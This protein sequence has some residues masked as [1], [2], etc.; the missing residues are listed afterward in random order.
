MSKIIEIH[1]HR[2]RALC[3]LRITML[4]ITKYITSTII[5]W[6]GM[7]SLAFNTMF[8][9]QCKIVMQV[10]NL[11]LVIVKI[12][13]VFVTVITNSSTFNFH[14]QFW[15]TAWFF[16]TS[17][18]NLDPSSLCSGRVLLQCVQNCLGDLNIN[19]CICK[20]GVKS[21]VLCDT[22]CILW[23]IVYRL[24]CGV[25]FGLFS[26][27]PLI[28]LGSTGPVYVFEK[29][30]YQLCSDQGWDYLSLRLWIGLWVAAI[31]I[32]LVAID[33]SAYVCYI[34]R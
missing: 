12:F 30:L 2:D 10:Q 18:C 26:G 15:P 4:Q 21:C 23:Y 24:I 1:H 33:A 16:I 9:S 20:C 8:S 29:I 27:Q 22:Q 25:L 17:I 34:T 11:W 19:L 31:L 7:H 14:C 5:H 28:L 6:F 13:I 3:L 32:L